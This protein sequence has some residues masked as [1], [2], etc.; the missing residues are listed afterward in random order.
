MATLLI[1]YDLEQGADYTPIETAIKSLGGSWWHGLDLARRDPTRSRGSAQK[2]EREG[3]K[4][5]LTK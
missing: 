1:G 5:E 3:A 4:L 2:A